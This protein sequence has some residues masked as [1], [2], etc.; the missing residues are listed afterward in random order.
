MPKGVTKFVNGY[1]SVDLTKGVTEF[2]NGCSGGVDLKKGV[3]NLL[4]VQ[5]CRFDKRCYKIS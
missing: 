4:M 3:T 5:G 1:R 2:F